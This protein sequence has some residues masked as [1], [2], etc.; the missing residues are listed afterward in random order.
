MP[1]F[2]TLAVPRFIKAN[3][4]PV[5]LAGYAFQR[6]RK[7]NKLP[8]AVTRQMWSLCASGGVKSLAKEAAA[9][10]SMFPDGDYPSRIFS[11][12]VE[13]SKKGKRKLS[14]CEQDTEE[15]DSEVLF[16]LLMSFSTEIVA[17]RVVG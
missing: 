2:C 1:L 15:S 17:G 8:A 4:L 10:A 16:A 5:A 13:E 7:E 3:N 11:G 14:I 6:R 12:E 9:I